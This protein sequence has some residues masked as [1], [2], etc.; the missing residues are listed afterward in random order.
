MALVVLAGGGVRPARIRRGAKAVFELQ[1]EMDR[2][3]RERL[4]NLG[5]GKEIAA[6]LSAFHTKNF[7]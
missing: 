4:Q 1:Q 7:M 5:F 2:T 3:R 6:R